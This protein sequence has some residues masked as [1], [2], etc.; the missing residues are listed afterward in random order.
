MRLSGDK[1]DPG[2]DPL[3]CINASI[4]FDGEMVSDVVTADEELGF[5]IKNKR[6][7]NGSFVINR[8]RTEIET[9]ALAGKVQILTNNK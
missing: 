7:V 4:L 9:E 3:L 5:I 6:D 2:Y 8:E 1:R